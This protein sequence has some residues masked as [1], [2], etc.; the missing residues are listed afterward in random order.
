MKH[1]DEELI[2]AVYADKAKFL[3]E[4]YEEDGA[5]QTYE[6]EG[7][8]FQVFVSGPDKYLIPELGVTRVS[9]RLEEHERWVLKNTQDGRTYDPQF[10]LD[11]E[12]TEEQA[13]ARIERC[14]KDYP[15]NKKWYKLEKEKSM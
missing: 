15:K 6:Y 10:Y 14:I 5:I 8:Y 1:T 7:E 9:P 12:L 13:L 3:E 4:E 11:G 2:D